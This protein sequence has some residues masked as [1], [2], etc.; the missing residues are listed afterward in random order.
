M[1]LT[2]SARQR[3]YHPAEFKAQLIAL[4]QQPGASVAG[5]ALAHGVCTSLLHRW[6]RQHAG[7][8][9]RSIPALV[10]IRLETPMAVQADDALRLEVHRGSTRVLIHCPAV[11]VEPCAR[12]L[13][14]WLK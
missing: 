14:A 4:C 9:P 10:P 11:S 13:G 6:I 5:V 1:D 8:L 12:L 2:P 7:S 3:R